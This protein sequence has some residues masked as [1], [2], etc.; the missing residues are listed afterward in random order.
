MIQKFHHDHHQCQK[1]D[2]VDGDP[3]IYL[4][5]DCSCLAPLYHWL[6]SLCWG[7]RTLFTFSFTLS[8][9]S[10]IFC[11]S[12]SIHFLCDSYSSLSTSL[13][14]FPGLWTYSGPKSSG[15]ST[16]VHLRTSVYK[17]LVPCTNL[18]DMWLLHYCSLRLRRYF[19]KILV[20]LH[21]MSF[22]KVRLESSSTGSSFPADYA[23]SVPFAAVSLD[24]R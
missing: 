1:T 3:P 12:S 4:L 17:H 10:L 2:V 7:S 9:P 6:Y 14:S 15:K 19:L 16:G 5:T 21:F 22:H 23:K 11:F 13:S 24:S 8:Y 20:I 18:H